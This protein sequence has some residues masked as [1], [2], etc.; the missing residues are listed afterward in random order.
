MC[1]HGVAACCMALCLYY[2]YLGLVV[3]R[4]RLRRHRHKKEKQRQETREAEARRLQL[5]QV[6]S[7]LLN[8][9][10]RYDL[11]EWTR[12]EPSPEHVE[13]N[14]AIKRGNAA[15]TRTP[16]LR[17]YTSVTDERIAT[18]RSGSRQ[19]NVTGAVVLDE[20]FDGT[21]SSNSPQRRMT[22]WTPEERFRSSWKGSPVRA[23]ECQQRQL[24]A[25]LQAAAREHRK[26]YVAVDEARLREAME[27]STECLNAQ[28]R[29]CRR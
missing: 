4:Q 29:I 17:D 13:G 3:R 25:S 22:L 19:H 12:C 5:L 27:G 28:S 20:T 21:P 1:A 24:A 10:E 26:H 23:G 18:V 14:H 8:L 7:M 6:L 2:L 15:S 16:S 11:E 9:D